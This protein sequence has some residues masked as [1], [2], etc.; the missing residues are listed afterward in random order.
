MDPGPWDTV[1]FAFFGGFLN[2]FQKK[3][4]KFQ[5]SKG[6]TYAFYASRPPPLGGAGGRGLAKATKKKEASI[7]ITGLITG[8]VSGL[9]GFAGFCRLLSACRLL[10][11][12]FLD[13]RKA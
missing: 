13:S 7:V 8:L 12:F 1:S 10:S 2:N 6:E 4:S 9:A 3:S 5:P 11:S